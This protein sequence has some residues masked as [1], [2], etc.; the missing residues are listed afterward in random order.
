MLVYFDKKKIINYIILGIIIVFIFGVL[1][2]ISPEYLTYG[3][4]NDLMKRVSI[5]VVLAVGVTIVIISGYSENLKAK[6]T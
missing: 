6:L 3:F 1:A 4:F 5:V 2:I